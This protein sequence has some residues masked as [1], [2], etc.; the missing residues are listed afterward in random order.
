M[1]HITP[2]VKDNNQRTNNN[3]K[4]HNDSMQAIMA[5][6]LQKQEEAKARKYQASSATDILNLLGD[7]DMDSEKNKQDVI[8]LKQNYSDNSITHLFTTMM[9]FAKNNLLSESSFKFLKG[10]MVIIE[11]I[12]KVITSLANV[13]LMT[14]PNLNSFMSLPA[15][16]SLNVLFDLIS[17]DDKKDLNQTTFDKI[18][19][20]AKP[21]TESMLDGINTSKGASSLAEALLNCAKNSIDDEAILQK[22]K[23]H[24]LPKSF[25]SAVIGA[26]AKGLELSKSMLDKLIVSDNPEQ[27]LDS[28][29]KTIASKIAKIKP[30]SFVAQASSYV[31]SEAVLKAVKKSPIANKLAKAVIDLKAKGMELSKD[32]LDNLVESDKPEDFLNSVLSGFSTKKTDEAK[33]VEGTK[34]P[35]ETN[36]SKEKVSPLLETAAKVLVKGATKYA[37]K[38]LS[39]GASSIFSSAFK[40]FA[41]PAKA[42][43]PKSPEQSFSEKSVADNIN[44]EEDVAFSAPGC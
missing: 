4:K 6:L 37:T 44:P 26:K 2:S 33:Q 43:P 28:T 20:A 40:L 1:P 30:D 11:S 10:S 5:E 23:E 32:T 35:E 34:Q 25:A 13:G 27:L 38:A 15:L 12:L 9:L 42:E 17:S 8:K 21:I 36:E 19:K 16:K 3:R 14:S 7:V 29:L 22:V 18:L 31:D 39:A 41:T 24:P